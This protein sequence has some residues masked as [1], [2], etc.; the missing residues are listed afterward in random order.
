MEMKMIFSDGSDVYTIGT[1]R[2]VCPTS[3]T[4]ATTMAAYIRTFGRGPDVV[5][6]ETTMPAK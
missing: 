2:A 4:T 6:H 3:M 1:V 5:G